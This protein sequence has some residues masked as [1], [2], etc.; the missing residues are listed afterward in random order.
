M[1]RKAPSLLSQAGWGLIR[2][3][4]SL[5]SFHQRLFTFAPVGDGGSIWCRWYTWYP[6]DKNSL[7][8]WRLQIFS[9]S[10]QKIGGARQSESKLSLLSLAQSL[11]KI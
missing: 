5:R 6:L 7:K 1:T 8:I 4:H 10:L 2:R 3:L 11:Q 9:V